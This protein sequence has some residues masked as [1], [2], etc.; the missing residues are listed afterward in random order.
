MQTTGNCGFDNISPNVHFG[1]LPG[2]VHSGFLPG[3]VLQGAGVQPS[4]SCIQSNL[5]SQNHVGHSGGGSFV[6]AS[7]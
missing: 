1:F 3:G 2:G 7:P 6:Q 4:V 5:A